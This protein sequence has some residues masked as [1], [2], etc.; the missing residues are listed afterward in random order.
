MLGSTRFKLQLLQHQRYFALCSSLLKSSVK[1]E[2]YNAELLMK[3]RDT[4]DF[5]KRRLGFCVI[6]ITYLNYYLTELKKSSS[7]TKTKKPL[8]YT[9]YYAFP[10]L[11]TF[12]LRVSNKLHLIL[13]KFIYSMSRELS[14]KKI[15]KPSALKHMKLKME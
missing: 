15:F 2:P 13:H 7:R 9:S 10:S 3:S 14:D 5:S 6:D 12:I 1:S 4:C 11:F 8:Q